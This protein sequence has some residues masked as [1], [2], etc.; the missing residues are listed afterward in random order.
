MLLPQGEKAEG[1]EAGGHFQYSRINI[2]HQ[3]SSV[4]SLSTSDSLHSIQ[5]S[6]KMFNSFYQVIMTV[7]NKILIFWNVI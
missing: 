5:V 4:Q 6:Q 1:L 3:F 2:A 7:M